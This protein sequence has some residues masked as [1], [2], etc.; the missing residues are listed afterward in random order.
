[1]GAAVVA[2]S[3]G[4][5]SSLL[6]HAAKEALGD[7]VLAVTAVSPTFAAAEREEAVSIAKAW[8]VRHRL[9]ETDEL[10]IPGFAGN[11]PDRC[12]HCKK[13][14]FGSLSRI[15]REE[16]FAAVCDGSNA[17]DARARRPG[18]RAARELGVRSPLEEAGLSKEAIRAL[19]RSFGLPTAER[20]SFAC[21]ASRFPY[22]TPIDREKLAR[23]EAC[24]DALRR[25]G[26]RQFRV[27]VHGAV[28]RIEVGR[29]EIPRLFEPATSDAVHDRFRRN[30]FLYVSV[31]LLGYRTG[32]MDEALPEAGPGRGLVDG[33]PDDLL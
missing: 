6:L 16:G 27:R 30:G 12:Y 31:D 19:S 18:R 28:A 3:G 25:L 32:S 2:F 1:M 7:R 20:G 14:L 11:P 21:L 4:V 15:A 23:V 24:E 13:E 9:V 33:P 29:D 8:G 22:G 10:S 17:D 5:D 26:F